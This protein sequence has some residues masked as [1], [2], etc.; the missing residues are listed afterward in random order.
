VRAEF[1]FSCEVPSHISAAQFADCV[2]EELTTLMKIMGA[3]GQFEF[4]LLPNTS[5]RNRKVMVR[6]PVVI[7][8]DR[9]WAAV[10]YSAMPAELGQAEAALFLDDKTIARHTVWLS[11]E[12]PIPEE[13]CVKGS[14][15]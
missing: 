5:R 4:S 9:E 13:L 2:R 14:V 7:T 12:L 8:A 6:V 1:R 10:A 11:G 15:E 3:S